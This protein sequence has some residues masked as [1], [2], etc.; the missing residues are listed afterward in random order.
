MKQILRFS[1]RR[2]LYI[3]KQA[4]GSVNLEDCGEERN[5]DEE[6]EKVGEAYN[7]G[8][9]YRVPILIHDWQINVDFQNL[10]DA[11]WFG[12]PL[13]YSGN[14][15]PD[16]EPILKENL[17]GRAKKFFEYMQDRCSEMEFEGF[18]VKPPTTIP[19]YGTDGPFVCTLRDCLLYTSPS[20]RD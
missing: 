17:L 7:Q 20:P 12:C 1:R 3:P 2:V 5:K 18:P 11:G 16:V 14:D 13:K 10:Y 4:I 15:V 9:P 19:G 6:V 8:K